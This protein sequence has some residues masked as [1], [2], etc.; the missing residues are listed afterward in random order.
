MNAKQLELPTWG[1]RRKGAGRKAKGPLRRVSHK[2]RPAH[3]RRFPL[4]AVLRS[5]EDVP[6]LRK[7]EMFAAIREALH[8][9]AEREGFRVVHYSVQGNH[10]HLVVEAVDTRALSRGMQGLAV[11]IARALNRVALRRGRVFAD[12]YFARELKTPAEVRRAVRYV[13]DNFMLHHHLDPQ[14]D[15]RAA[16]LIPARTWLLTVG[17]QRSRA[18]PLPVAY[19]ALPA[20]DGLP[21]ACRER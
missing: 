14:T 6:R 7:K 3:A 20:G 17:W 19:W 2:R 4:H 12:H 5:R 16:S 8:A 1:G 11:R 13:L 9:G 10:I 15:D 18:G 21:S